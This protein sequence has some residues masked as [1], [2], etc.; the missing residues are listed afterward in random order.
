MSRP[1]RANKKENINTPRVCIVYCFLLKKFYTLFLMTIALD[2]STWIAI[3]GAEILR[4]KTH[5]GERLNDSVA[6]L[7]SETHVA[8]FLMIQFTLI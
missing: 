2:Q 3:I 7:R 1:Q 4:H 8:N 5:S 6:I